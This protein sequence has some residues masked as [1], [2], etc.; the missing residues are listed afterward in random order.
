MIFFLFLDENI[1][2]GYSLEAPQGGASNAYPR[3]MLVQKLENI[4]TFWF[5]SALS[6]AVNTDGQLFLGERYIST[7]RP[8]VSHIHVKQ[9]FFLRLRGMRDHPAS[10]V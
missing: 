2:C 10:A 1:C 6:G 3:H 7:A 5:K 8:L 9:G 4:H